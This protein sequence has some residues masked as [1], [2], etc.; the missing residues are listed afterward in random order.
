VTTQ[1]P[2]RAAVPLVWDKLHA[3]R[4]L[5]SIRIMIVDDHAVLRE[6]LRLL[7]ETRTEISVVGEA[8]DGRQ[9]IDLAERLHPDVILMDASMPGL[10]GIEA[11]AV[12][13]KRLPRTKVLVLSGYA[14]EDRVA[15]ALAAGASGYVLKSS[16]SD[17]L[18]RAIVTVNTDQRYLSAGLTERPAAQTADRVAADGVPLSSRER[19][20]LQLVAEGYTNAGIAQR[21]F[22]SVKTVEAHKEHI[23]QKL[24]IRGAAELIRYAIRKGIVFIEP[25]EPQQLSAAG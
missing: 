3:R 13:K 2:A 15:A 7:L 9:A 12:I 25:D 17:E 16:T 14:Y 18:L 6:T 22:I 10:N 21:L 11:T 23:A 8:A 19:E 24:G 1:T 5:A 4:V 20:V